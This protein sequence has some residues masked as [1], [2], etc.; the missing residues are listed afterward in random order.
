MLPD[1]ISSVVSILALVLLLRVWHPAQSFRFAQRA[2][3][4]DETGRAAAG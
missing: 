1:I 4:D 3:A 2:A